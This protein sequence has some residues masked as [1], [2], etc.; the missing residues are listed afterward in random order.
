MVLIVRLGIP[1]FSGRDVVAGIIMGNYLNSLIA[2]L[3]AGRLIL[4]WLPV[5]PLRSADIFCPC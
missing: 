1:V 5:F 4:A 2:R 3:Q